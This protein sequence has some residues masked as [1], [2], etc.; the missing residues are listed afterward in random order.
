M[1]EEPCDVIVHWQDA[2]GQTQVQHVTSHR[3]LNDLANASEWPALPPPANAQALAQL[4]PP[5]PAPRPAEPAA[6]HQHPRQE[7]RQV[8]PPPAPRSGPRTI[9]R[10]LLQ[11]PQTDRFALAPPR[12]YEQH[13]PRDVRPPHREPE[14]SDRIP[15]HTNSLDRDQNGHQLLPPPDRVTND[16][17][18]RIAHLLTKHAQLT[19]HLTQNW[20]KL[21]SAIQ[22][23]INHTTS[24]VTV[25]AK[26]REFE[27]SITKAAG[28]FGDDIQ[29]VAR[30]HLTSSIAAIEEE[31]YST[32][33]E[34][35]G[36]A[37]MIAMRDFQQRFAGTKYRARSYAIQAISKSAGHI[38][39]AT[40]YP[41][42]PHI[43]AINPF[44]IFPPENNSSTIPPEEPQ[45][46]RRGLTHKDPPL[47]PR[48]AEGTTGSGTPPPPVAPIREPENY[49]NVKTT[50]RFGLLIDLDYD[51]NLPTTSHEDDD[52]SLPPPPKNPKPTKTPSPKKQLNVTAKPIKTPTPNG[53]NPQV[54]SP[55]L[56]PPSPHASMRTDTI[57][58]TPPTPPPP[59]TIEREPNQPRQLTPVTSPLD[60]NT[61]I[62]S[63]VF[64]NFDQL[65]AN[66]PLISE[67]IK[68]NIMTDMPALLSKHNLDLSIIQIDTNDNDSMI[69]MNENV[70]K[71]RTSRMDSTPLQLKPIFCGDLL[72]DS[73]EIPVVHN[74]ISKE[75]RINELFKDVSDNDI[76]LAEAQSLSN[77]LPR[78][79]ISPTI[80]FK[81]APASMPSESTC[82]VKA[83]AETIERPITELV[84]Q[85]ELY[86][87][88]KPIKTPNRSTQN[89][90]SFFTIQVPNVGTV[91]VLK[92]PHFDVEDPTTKIGF[93]APDHKTNLQN[94]KREFDPNVLK[95]LS[96]GGESDADESVK[97]R[98]TRTNDRVPPSPSNTSLV[99][100]KTLADK[101]SEFVTPT[102]PPNVNSN[103]SVTH[104]LTSQRRM[105]PI[106]ASRPLPLNAPSTGKAQVPSPLP[107]TASD[108]ERF[109]KRGQFLS[110]PIQI[111]A[112]V[113][114]LIIGDS[115]I[116][117]YRNIPTNVQIICIPG[118]DFE[119]I[120]DA[121]HPLIR[122]CKKTLKHLVIAAGVNERD[123]HDM[124]LA[125]RDLKTLLETAKQISFDVHFVTITTP[126]DYPITSRQTQVLYL[127]NKA[128]AN[129]PLAIH[130]IPITKGLLADPKDISRLH[131]SPL[132]AKT[133]FLTILGHL[134]SLN[135]KGRPPIS[136]T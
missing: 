128:A 27:A 77:L 47:P 45:P 83:P 56:G 15:V 133:I 37:A 69:E 73:P 95:Y 101:A 41:P 136:P 6:P 59:P 74:N 122:R 17:D 97:D 115:N 112:G 18:H 52:W 3:A 78:D 24:S 16:E 110:E 64:D 104:G 31:L 113:D 130:L 118:A 119:V 127:L 4:P 105:G 114:T 94:M 107:T 54:L 98:P 72:E 5:R 46:R 39:A 121:L 21:P 32:E 55:K 116:K 100:T 20:C 134:N 65:L 9:S 81:P 68:I 102:N 8:P 82:V 90:E 36:G 92:P 91:K 61:K 29:L 53:S 33:P 132:S 85:N 49:F 109:I 58:Q 7:T 19:H 10:P 129:K 38:A 28:R 11:V 67:K 35:A 22:E 124:A 13:Q 103:T 86:L 63:H 50:N 135:C 89:N 23:N 60:I 99:Q 125:T 80:S 93:T 40:R 96:D 120:N 26:T 42:Y 106:R 25:P 108:R 66:S 79:V 84:Q 70:T 62:D 111:V 48:G 30:Q 126:V 44:H 12:A 34:R 131:F 76:L 1:Y 123:V 2:Q 14:A 117:Y 87:T 51:E 57:P 71:T 43:L 88:N 75:E